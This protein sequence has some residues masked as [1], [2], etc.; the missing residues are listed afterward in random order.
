MGEKI[1]SLVDNFQGAGNHTISWDASNYPSGI[2]LVRLEGKNVLNYL[3]YEN[4]F[5]RSRR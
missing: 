1:I 5:S 2:Y 4:N 3:N